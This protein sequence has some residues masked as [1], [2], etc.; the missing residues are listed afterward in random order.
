MPGAK[1]SVAH[2]AESLDRD[3]FSLSENRLAVAVN[4]G[5]WIVDPG[6][7]INVAAVSQTRFW[8]QNDLD[9]KIKMSML[10]DQ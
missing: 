6:L 8:W 3:I 9:G 7:G 5:D 10:S 4:E 2:Y 1:I